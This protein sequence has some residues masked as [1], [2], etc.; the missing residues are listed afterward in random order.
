MAK[1]TAVVV[2][3]PNG[4]PTVSNKDF[5]GE[6]DADSDDAQSDAS[7]DE[8]VAEDGEVAS[9]AEDS[10]EEE[11]DSPP[12][13]PTKAKRAQRTPKARSNSKSK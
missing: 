1:N 10:D 2:P 3:V 7:D 11:V 5:F 6:D 9:G 8:A 4:S 13:T 12:S